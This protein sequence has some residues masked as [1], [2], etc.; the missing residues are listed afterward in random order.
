MYGG[1]ELPLR[2]FLFFGYF[3]FKRN[4]ERQRKLKKKKKERKKDKERK[5]K[6]KEIKNP[7]KFL[8]MYPLGTYFIF[9]ICR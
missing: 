7:K 1:R 2:N 6:R 9:Y 3:F 5:D 4:K 8:H